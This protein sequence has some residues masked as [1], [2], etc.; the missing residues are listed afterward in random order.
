MYIIRIRSGALYITAERIRTCFRPYGLGCPECYRCRIPVGIPEM[1][2]ICAAVYIL[3]PLAV[4]IRYHIS[5][6]IPAC[7]SGSILLKARIYKNIVERRSYYFDGQY[8]LIFLTAFRYNTMNDIIPDLVCVDQF[9]L[10]LIPFYFQL[11]FRTIVIYSSCRRIYKALS[12]RNFFFQSALH[13]GNCQFS[14]C[15]CTNHAVDLSRGKRFSVK[16]KP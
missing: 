14:L 9:L 8:D 6:H 10:V 2:R 12:H 16:V 7:M 3:S 1:H 15:S 13:T 11:L 4:I 5:C